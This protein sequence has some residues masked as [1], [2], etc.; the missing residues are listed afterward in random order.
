M[1][2]MPI[3]TLNPYHNLHNN[4]KQLHNNNNPGKKWARL[5]TEVKNCT[6]SCGRY[7][8]NFIILD[9]SSLS[10]HEI[11]CSITFLELRLPHLF[12]DFEGNSFDIP[13][14]HHVFDHFL[15]VSLVKKN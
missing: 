1:A 13:V 14:R 9:P 12:Q 11:P 4:N 15:E 3:P 5:G 2:L 7:S 6:C 10:R 8:F